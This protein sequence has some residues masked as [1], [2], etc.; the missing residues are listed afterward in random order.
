MEKSIANDILKTLN[1]SSSLID[2]TLAELKNTCPPEYFRPCAKLLGRT[3]SDIFD[4]LMAPIYDEHQDLAPDWYRDGSPRAKPEI[5]RLKLSS[6][7]KYALLS[8]FEAAY[9]RIQSTLSSLSGLL[10]P[11]E[12][13]LYS[14]GLHQVSVALCHARV[15]LLMAETDEIA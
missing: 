10:N 9:Q 8:A 13:A 6:E 7:A 14:Q 12:T 4:H 15:T 1:E 2:Q 5:A 11:L 3:M